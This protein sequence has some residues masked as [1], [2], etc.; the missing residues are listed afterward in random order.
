[1]QSNFFGRKSCT[2]FPV[3]VHYNQENV[4]KQFSAVFISDTTKHGCTEVYAFLSVLNDHL[5]EIF[6]ER[7][8]QV[9]VSDGAAQVRRAFPFHQITLLLPNIIVLPQSNILFSISNSEATLL[10]SPVTLTTMVWM[11]SGISMQAHMGKIS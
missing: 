8:Y 9:Y 3:I 7:V 6:P 1:M 11:Q 5:Q 4:V 2:I 10:I